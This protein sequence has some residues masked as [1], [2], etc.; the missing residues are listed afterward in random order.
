L[1]QDS[2]HSGRV[3]LAAIALGLIAQFAPG[4]APPAKAEIT[5]ANTPEIAR[6]EAY[7]N[8]FQS[9]RG[10]FLQI[11]ADGGAAEGK[12]WLQRPG[13]V[14]FEYAPPVPILIVADG[15]DLVFHDRELG[16]IERLPI[17]AT[18]IGVLAREPIRFGDDVAV[19]SVAGAAGILRITVTDRHRPEA[20][21]LTI[22]FEDKPL[23]LRQWLIKDARG[24]TTSVQLL[25]IETNPMLSPELFVFNNAEGERR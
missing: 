10:D 11:A 24:E 13:R 2:L 14:R 25:N 19:K 15:T 20:G 8:S 16:Q 23:K 1:A 4:Y 9:L 5:A 18:P 7:L 3:Y 22:V 12:W 17:L 6:I 21:E